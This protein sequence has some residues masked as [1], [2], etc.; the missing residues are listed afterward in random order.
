MNDWKASYPRNVAA[1]HYVND[2]YVPPSGGG[3]T[4]SVMMWKTADQA[5]LSET[6]TKVINYASSVQVGDNYTVD[7]AAG[8]IQPKTPGL[9]EVTAR[10][11]FL[12]DEIP[13][14]GII[15]LTLWR[16]GAFDTT[17]EL[18]GN[19]AQKTLTDHGPATT[20]E[21]SVTYQLEDDGISGTSPWPIYMKALCTGGN[22]SVGYLAEL[23]IYSC[24]ISVKKLGEVA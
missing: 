11:V 16:M 4:E 1:M 15:Q 18:P 22:I 13:E 7:L 23:G 9:Y 17:N 10:C 8:T 6:D 20:L 14:V 24:S 19:S 21:T 5:I 3:S 2:L 12:L